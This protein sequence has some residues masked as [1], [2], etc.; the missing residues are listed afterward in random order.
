MNIISILTIVII[1]LLFYYRYKSDDLNKEQD[2][3]EITKEIDSEIVDDIE[4]EIATQ[5]DPDVVLIKPEIVAT[6]NSFLYP[7]D[8]FGKK[9]YETTDKIITD[10]AKETKFE[11]IN[12]IITDDTLEIT[13]KIVATRNSYL[14][15]EDDFGKLE[16]GVVSDSV[17]YA[18]DLNENKSDDKNLVILPEKK[19]Y[20]A[21]R[22]KRRR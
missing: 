19:P 15:P 8:D 3:S 6:R 4:P 9:V 13:P 2:A 10:I 5:D 1:A 18:Y 12:E 7:E 11:A 21:K 16:K 17:T 22:K 20:Q 14:Y